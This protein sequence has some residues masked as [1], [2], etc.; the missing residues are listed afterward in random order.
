[1]YIQLGYTYIRVGD[2]ARLPLPGK[3]GELQSVLI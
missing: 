1:V 2:L 3:A